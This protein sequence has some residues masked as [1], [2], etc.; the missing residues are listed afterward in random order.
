MGLCWACSHVCWRWCWR[1]WGWWDAAAATPEPAAPVCVSSR[2]W[3]CRC[4]HSKWQL[5]SSQAIRWWHGRHNRQPAAAALSGS[6]PGKL[7]RTAQAAAAARVLRPAAAGG[8][9]AAAGAGGQ[10]G[11]REWQ[12]QAG[13]QRWQQQHAAALRPPAHGRP[14]NGSHD[15][16]QLAPG[17]TDAAAAAHD[18]GSSGSGGSSTPAT[19]WGRRWGRDDDATTRV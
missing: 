9:G 14:P 17:A 2:C 18:D 7:Q 16:L 4:C 6:T 3:C 13:R 8:A 11:W 10:Q 12:R 19:A 1:W 5:R 15:P